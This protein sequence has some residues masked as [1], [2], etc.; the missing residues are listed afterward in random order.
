VE[1]G[2]ANEIAFEGPKQT[3]IP[4][5]Q[6]GIL[7]GEEGREEIAHGSSED[8]GGQQFPIPWR[9]SRGLRL[10]TKII[11]RKDRERRDCIVGNSNCVS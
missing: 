2:G 7:I 6:Q 3:T 4:R 5:P 11:R 1:S 8:R 9:A 10:K